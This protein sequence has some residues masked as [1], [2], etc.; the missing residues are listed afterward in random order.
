[1][2]N[3]FVVVL[4]T[5]QYSLSVLILY[6]REPALQI[7]DWRPLSFVVPLCIASIYKRELAL[8]IGGL[9]LS[10][11]LSVLILDTKESLLSRS[12]ASLGCIASLY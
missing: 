5:K 8:Q 11:S 3:L 10:Y 4:D 2:Y 9:S 7:A 1:M 12:E 6:T